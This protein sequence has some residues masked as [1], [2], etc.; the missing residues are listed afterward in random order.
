MKKEIICFYDESNHSR[1]LTSETLN[2]T[3]FRFDFVSV[4]VGICKDKYEQFEK[5]FLIFENKWKKFY[6][7]DELKSTV[8]KNKKYKFGLKTFKNDDIK[9]YSELYNLLL[10]YNVY[11]HCGIFNKIQYLVN[12]LLLSPVLASKIKFDTTS[13]SISKFLN[14]YHP[15]KVI[16]S[17][18]NNIDDFIPEFR[19]FLIKRKQLNT[20]IHGESEDNMINQV[21]A[22]FDD[23]N[24]DIKLQWNY[25]FSFDGLRKYL[26][27]LNL[28][29]IKLYIDKEGNG[30]TQASAINDGFN[31]TEEVD[32][33]N[34][35]GV[36]CADLLAGFI[37]NMIYEIQCET[38]YSEDGMTREESLLGINWFKNISSDIFSLYKSTFK[39]FIETNNS[40]Y[41]FYR[42][43]YHDGLLYFLALLKE[44]ARYYNFEEY[45]K[46][47]AE[48]HQR[49]VYSILFYDLKAHLDDLNGAYKVEI[50]NTEEVYNAKGAKIFFDI[51]QYSPLELPQNNQ[52]KKYF[53]L[54]FGILEPSRK[55]TITISDN[56]V[57]KC[58][59]LPNEFFSIVM[60]FI[61][62]SM[63]GNNM[64]PSFV[65]ITNENNEFH[66]KLSDD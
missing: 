23:I 65:T 12:Q 60:E 10:D 51:K 49:N 40:W 25:I 17:I 34:S 43:S 54:S 22:I 56:G 9:F 48:E 14:V 3:N 37:A 33:K 5:D 7:C 38:F 31:N 57:P 45:I 18:E 21:L 53:A 63:M 35:I 39:L 41:K 46:V 29:C 55:P 11:L 4:I 27:E 64:F 30:K 1:K 15:A 24:L 59:L 16:D 66:I 61:G 36:R 44:F 28:N 19:T 47:S 2:D 58:Y 20:R 52:S 6:S 42:S 32:S 50:V 8:I 13:Y 62:Y 26:E